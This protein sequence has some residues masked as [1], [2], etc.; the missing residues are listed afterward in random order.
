[1]HRCSVDTNAWVDASTGWGIG[2]IIGQQWTAWRLT[3]GWN[4]HGRDISQAKC[5]ALELSVLMI[6]EQG[7]INSHVMIQGDNTNVIKKDRL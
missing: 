1:M 3:P 6:I 5:I 4:K 2:I 7:F